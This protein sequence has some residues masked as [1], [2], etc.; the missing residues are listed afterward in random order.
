MERQLPEQLNVENFN[1]NSNNKTKQAA[2]ITTTNPDN[3]K[4]YTPI[5]AIISDENGINLE[6]QNNWQFILL[7]EDEAIFNKAKKIFIENNNKGLRNIDENQIYKLSLN[8]N[9]EQNQTQEEKLE[10]ALADIETLTKEENHD[11]LL[12]TLEE[13]KKNDEDQEIRL[14]TEQNHNLLLATLEEIKKNDEDQEIRLT[15]EQNKLKELLKSGR[16]EK[17]EQ[18][19]RENPQ[20]IYLD[21]SQDKKNEKEKEINLDEIS[22]EEI[23]KKLNETLEK[24][25]EL[26]N[27]IAQKKPEISPEILQNLINPQFSN[28]FK[29]ASQ[30]FV[31]KYKN[32]LEKP[33]QKE[34]A[35][36]QTKIE[37]GN[38]SYEDIF[39][40]NN[41][42]NYGNNFLVQNFA[43]MEDDLKKVKK[44]MQ[45]ADSKIA[46]SIS[47]IDNETNLSDTKTL[48]SMILMATPF[49]L[50]ALGFDY[51]DSLGEVISP[52]IEVAKETPI[53]NEV[54]NEISAIANLGPIDGL[55]NVGTFSNAL[56][57]HAPLAYLGGVNLFSRIK[58]K[59]EIREKELPKL[60]KAQDD[61]LKKYQEERSGVI[62]N[63]PNL[64]KK[65]EIDE[66][67]KLAKSQN[68][69]LQ[70]LDGKYAENEPIR[71]KI[72]KF[73]TEKEIEKNEKQIFQKLCEDKSF[74]QE[75]K[76]FIEENK[77]PLPDKKLES[78]IES[79]IGNLKSST[80]Y[81]SQSQDSQKTI[82]LG[83]NHF[84]T[85]PNDKLID[86][87]VNFT[88]NSRENSNNDNSR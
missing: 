86:F 18:K 69:I 72:D 50:A 5:I 28:Q 83:E 27:N 30:Q 24:K 61:N 87:S 66:L 60:R 55:I 80:S 82:K 46:A 63:N 19:P 22:L 35:N 14:T 54:I 45:L 20:E 21:R 70:I 71:N 84:F 62:Y 47:Q 64:V 51:L 26:I 7:E 13:I 53:I 16:K 31:E 78:E 4:N 12:A 29:Q 48:L 43:K 10:N 41:Y 38:Y 1:F 42:Q 3:T 39:L 75:A 81:E 77:I 17:F 8:F 9:L 58:D 65:T 73:L 67:K 37:S 88:P 36:L 52:I 40:L 34:I 44:T 6:N 56:I 23:E 59:A 32:C 25:E 49:G 15:T 11:L 68:E 85:N 57:I 2:I 76:K 33:Y 74:Y 79:V